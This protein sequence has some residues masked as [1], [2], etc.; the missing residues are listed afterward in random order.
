MSPPALPALMPLG[1]KE[2]DMMVVVLKAWVEV[3]VDVE[4]CMLE[5]DVQLPRASAMVSEATLAS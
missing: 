2:E 3:E 4:V 5:G 1:V